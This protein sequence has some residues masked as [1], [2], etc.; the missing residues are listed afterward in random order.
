MRAGIK[1][2]DRIMAVNG[3]STTG[4]S[5]NRAVDLITGPAGDVVTLSIKRE[6]ADK[7][8]DVPLT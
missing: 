8:I 7:P 2:Q 1:P 4:W 3:Q 6:G 5:L